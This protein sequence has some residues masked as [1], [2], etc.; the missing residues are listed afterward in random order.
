MKGGY[1]FES[2]PDLFPEGYL[3]QT[4]ISLWALY[5]DNKNKAAGK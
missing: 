1:L 3:T 4:E 2:R 5:Y